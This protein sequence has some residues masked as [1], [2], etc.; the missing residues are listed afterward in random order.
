MKSHLIISSVC[1]LSFFLHVPIS[2]N[3]QDVQTGGETSDRS[4]HQFAVNLL[5]TINT[6]EAVDHS[7]SGSYESWQALQTQHAEYF[8]QLM[9]RQHPANDH[10]V[11]PPEILPGWNLRM[12]MHADGQGYDI[13]LQ[14]TTDN[15]CGYAA[16]TNEGGIIWQ[17]KSVECEI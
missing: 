2:Q 4:R 9:R 11:D 15:K 13:L 8:E 5:R 10:L 3:P 6:A 7:K 17:A 16:I 14:D 12:N 1:V